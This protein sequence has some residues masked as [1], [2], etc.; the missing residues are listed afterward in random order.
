MMIEWEEEMPDWCL[1]N[2]KKYE[3]ESAYFNV[4]ESIVM[5]V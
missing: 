4:Y 3:K 2:T 1:I 5:A